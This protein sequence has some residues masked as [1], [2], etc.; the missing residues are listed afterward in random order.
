[1]LKTK[2][3]EMV[4]ILDKSGSMYEKEKD[5]IASYNHMLEKQKREGR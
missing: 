1:M 4:C 3:I 5:T 2:M